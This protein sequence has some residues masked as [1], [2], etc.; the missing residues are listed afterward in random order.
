MSELT[1]VSWFKGLGYLLLTVVTLVVSG[2]VVRTLIAI[3]RREVCV[4]EG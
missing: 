4:E 2:L 1:A 3:G